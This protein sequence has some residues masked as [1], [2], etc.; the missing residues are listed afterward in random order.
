MPVFWTQGQCVQIE[1]V[2]VAAAKRLYR[3]R[4]AGDHVRVQVFDAPPEVDVDTV[5][6]LHAWVETLE[7]RLHD[8]ETRGAIRQQL[9]DDEAWLYRV[10]GSTMRETIACHGPIT[11]NLI[12][13]VQKRL[14]GQLTAV[15]QV[16]DVQDDEHQKTHPGFIITCEECTT[17][18]VY[19]EN[20][21][22]FS[23]FSGTWGAVELVCAECGQRTEIVARD[24]TWRVSNGTAGRGNVGATAVPAPWHL[25]AGRRAAARR[26][27]STAVRR[28]ARKDGQLA[29][30]GVRAQRYNLCDVWT[31]LHVF[32]AGAP[33]RLAA[34][35]VV[36]EPVCG[37]RRDSHK[38]SH[39][40]L[41]LRRSEHVAE[42]ATNV[43]AV[44]P[45][46]VQ[47]GHG[48]TFRHRVGSC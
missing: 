39:R 14:V 15:T 34:E 18:H 8:W 11:R 5:A 22:G 37:R 3:E 17:R 36:S 41:R 31:S 43:L 35:A 33:G 24:T 30:A 16:K 29:L 21:L 10:I 4:C 46:E 1:A 20:S 13:S 38:R 7:A 12:A 6:R 44:Q 26:S 23:A 19:V 47:V 48:A 9:T 45:R 42:S 32:C 28:S 27:E 40:T 25:C 2:G